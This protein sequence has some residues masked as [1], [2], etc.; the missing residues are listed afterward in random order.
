MTYQ[1]TVGALKD[2]LRVEA[3]FDMMF[4]ELTVGHRSASMFFVDGLTKDEVLEKMLEFMAKVP[5]QDAAGIA[6][7]DEFI[8]RFITFI[9]VN[10]TADTE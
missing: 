7:A 4:R 8:K 5:E 6:D 10:R 2:K 3:S 1:E 9:E